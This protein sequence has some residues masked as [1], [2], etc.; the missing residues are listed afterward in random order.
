MSLPQK[1]KTIKQYSEYKLKEKGSLF[2]CICEPVQTE[3]EAI[4]FLAKIRKQYYDATHHCYSYKFQNGS[5]KYSDDGEPSGTAGIRIY[6]AQNHFDVTNI[7][8]VVVRYFGGTKLGI[9][10]LGKA[11]YDSAIDCLNNSVIE[12]KELFHKIELS[13]DFAL[14]KTVHH[15]VSKFKL[16]I[17]KNDFDIRPKMVCLV[18]SS[19]EKDFSSELIVASQNKVV[20][21]QTEEF[22]YI[23]LDSI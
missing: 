16:I 13:Y 21:T 1:I 22:S 4:S 23:I 9:G 20:I 3:E 2:L 18:R 15:F 7:V 14:S 5:F 10:P 12:Q 6:N 17:S 19:S 8:T 11:Y